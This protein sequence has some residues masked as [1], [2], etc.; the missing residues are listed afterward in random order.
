MNNNNIVNNNISNNSNI[1]SMFLIQ[2]MNG[3]SASEL[4]HLNIVN[5][6]GDGD[7]NVGFMNDVFNLKIVNM[8]DVL[9]AMIMIQMIEMLAVPVMRDLPWT[10][11]AQRLPLVLH[12]QVHEVLW[13]VRSTHRE[14]SLLDMQHLDQTTVGEVWRGDR[15]AGHLLCVRGLPVQEWEGR[16]AEKGCQCVSKHQ[17]LLHQSSVQGGFHQEGYMLITHLLGMAVVIDDAY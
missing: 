17:F 13:A 2:M 10:L 6:L 12:T 1:N 8:M 15:S 5:V 7:I 14:P 4:V 3:K 9:T 11:M 16:G